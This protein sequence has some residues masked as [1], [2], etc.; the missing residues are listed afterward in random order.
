MPEK[1][2][3]ARTWK[4][5]HPDRRN[6]LRKANYRSTVKN[7]RNSH[8]P[9]EPEE[10]S[11]IIAANRP[12]DR[13]LSALIGRSVQAIQVRRTKLLGRNKYP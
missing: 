6:A 3:S 9:W 7:A 8:K 11:A 12:R 1:I 10:D 4:K 2:S 13:E 5:R